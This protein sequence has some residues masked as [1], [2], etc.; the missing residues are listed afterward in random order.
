[1]T[2]SWWYWEPTVVRC[3]FQLCN[4]IPWRKLYKS[5]SKRFSVSLVRLNSSAVLVDN[6][7]RISRTQTFKVQLEVRLSFRQFC[8]TWNKE[9]WF[10]S[11]ITQNLTRWIKICNI[12]GRFWVIWLGFVW[13]YRSLFDLVIM[14]D[15]INN[16]IAGFEFVVIK[17]HSKRKTN[18]WEWPQNSCQY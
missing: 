7:N 1:M 16:S 5:R 17:R 10:P 18:K 13:F 4:A 6:W 3:I 9:T 15:G 11:K 8:R 2:P 12:S 14:I